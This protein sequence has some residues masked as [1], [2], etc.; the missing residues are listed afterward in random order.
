MQPADL[1]AALEANHGVFAAQLRGVPV[2]LRTWR[3]R[4]D[5]WCLLEV[6]CHLRDEEGEDFRARV[7]SVLEDPLR[8]PPS[9]DPQGWVAERA[10]MAQDYD[11]AV[12]AFLSA[13]E[14]S[15]AWLRGLGDAPWDNA[16][17]HPEYGPLSALFFLTNWVAHDYLH[18]RQITKVKFMYLD[19]HTD[20]TLAYAGEW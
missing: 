16:Y 15:L 10:Y 18:L 5:H 1:I 12:E 9:I 17:Q 4:A 3:P 2:A 20:A 7:A 11:A 8:R 6:A 14:A 19:A 13:R